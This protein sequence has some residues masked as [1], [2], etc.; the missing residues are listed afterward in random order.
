LLREQWLTLAVSLLLPA[1]AWIAAQVDLPA[2]RRVALAVASVVLVRLLLNGYVLDYAFGSWPVLNGLVA[3]YAL[4]AAAFGLAAAMV[5][6]QG[7][8]L[9]VGGLGGG[10]VGL[11]AGFGAVQ[12]RRGGGAEGGLPGGAFGFPEAVLDGGSLP[13]PSFATMRIAQRLGRP[14]L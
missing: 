13:V 3:A 9:G 10:C 12:D 14:V 11:G 1:L 6:R 5:R 2:L 7:D 8:R 4:P